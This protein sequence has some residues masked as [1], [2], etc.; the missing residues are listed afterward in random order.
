VPT[1]LP[2]LDY[3]IFGLDRSWTGQRWLYSITAQSGSPPLQLWLAHSQA[4]G[5]HPCTVVGNV[6]TCRYPGSTTTDRPLA[7]M[8][9][10]C[11]V[12]VS[13]GRLSDLPADR[14]SAY[15]R[16]VTPDVDHWAQETDEWAHLPWV[17]EGR[18]TSAPLFQFAG[19]WVS[20]SR[21]IPEVALIVLGTGP[22][23][24]QLR[25]ERVHDS[26]GYHF[27]SREA[28]A[29]P[30]VVTAAWQA[31]G[32]DPNLFWQRAIHPDQECY[33]GDGEAE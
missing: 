24:E 12:E 17:I 1:V 23:P 19:D 11:L 21:D 22:P 18:A 20:F 10:M 8:A 31:A 2:P 33:L 5:G 25:L 28:L 6:S 26:A 4:D 30:E 13:L 7:S 9:L 14:R 15:L 16:S 3:P 32:T 29:Y 27:S